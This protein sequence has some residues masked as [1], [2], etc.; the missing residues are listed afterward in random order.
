[1]NQDS[2]QVY[3]E[4]MASCPSMD[5]IRWFDLK[6]G[7]LC[8]KCGCNVRDLYSFYTNIGRHRYNSCVACYGDESQYIVAIGFSM[9]TPEI[10][11]YY[12]H[13]MVQHCKTSLESTQRTFHIKEK[14]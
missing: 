2:H 4:L 8:D 12:S 7:Y 9:Y 5:L 1:M 13:E 10:S 3:W 11:F 6:T 14:I